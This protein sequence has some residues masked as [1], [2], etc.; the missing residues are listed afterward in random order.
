MAVT[1]GGLKTLKPGDVLLTENADL[2]VYLGYYTG[3]LRPF[4]HSG[5]L[6]INIWVQAMHSYNWRTPG[7]VTDEDILYPD[8]EYPNS[9]RCLVNALKYPETF[10]CYVKHPKKFEELALHIDLTPIYDKIQ[11]IGPLT[12]IGDR[13]PRRS[14]D[15]DDNKIM[16]VPTMG[17]KKTFTNNDWTSM[18]ELR[19]TLVEF[20]KDLTP[21][22]G[23]EVERKWLVTDGPAF[24]AVLEKAALNDPLVTLTRKFVTTSYV[25]ISPEIRIRADFTMYHELIDYKIAYKGPAGEDGLERVE[26]EF[27]TTKE[28]YERL[29]AYVCSSV[30]Q[31]FNGSIPIQRHVWLAKYPD[32]FTYELK[33][34][35]H[36]N[37]WQLEVEFSNREVAM[38]FRMRQEFTEYVGNDVT[39]D[40][41]HKIKHY[42]ES[43]RLL[44]RSF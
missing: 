11:K 43:T 29:L 33:C 38:A 22:E 8:K 37:D 32:G 20:G 42:W 24:A 44:P 26:L 30:M 5:Y 31:P 13:K 1:A 3:N 25:S 39:S 35:D 27:A 18:E 36:G 28:I 10:A 21:D 17:E 6:Y 4:V 23:T 12:R 9:G 41:Y 40:P 14:E 7:E 16:E 19:D 34:A 15:S 2:Y